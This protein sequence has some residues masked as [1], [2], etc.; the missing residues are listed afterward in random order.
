MASAAVRQE[1]AKVRLLLLPL[2]TTPIR[3]HHCPAPLRPLP[4]LLLQEVILL[5]VQ[6]LVIMRIM[7]RR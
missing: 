1:L 7:T 6:T 3:V 5:Q 4:H 2:A